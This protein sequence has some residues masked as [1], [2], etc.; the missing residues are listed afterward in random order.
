MIVVNIFG[1]PGSG[2][3][4]S[5]AYI[6]YKLKEAGIN[7]ELVTEFAKDLVWED[8]Y[9]AISNQLYIAGNQYYRLSKL[10]G[11]VDVVVTDSPLMLQ[12]VYY[13]WN[14]G[15][16]PDMFDVII[17]GLDKQ[18]TNFNYI[19]PIPKKVDP[20][21]R[22]HTREDSINIYR[23]INEEFKKFNIEYTEKNIDV[24][25]YNEIVEDILDY[26]KFELGKEMD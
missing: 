25:S 18:Y 15:S 19:L 22:V 16:N 5:A 10:D 24:H 7:V 20:N 1:V 6:F 8:N 4:A 12:S 3:S 14:S 11:K 9:K 2:K 13:R 17:Y 23:L 26:L 21:G